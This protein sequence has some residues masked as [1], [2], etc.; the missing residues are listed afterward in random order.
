MNNS[1]ARDLNPQGWSGVEKVTVPRLHRWEKKEE[2]KA[3]HASRSASYLSKRESTNFCRI[4]RFRLVFFAS[5]SSAASRA[6]L[7]VEIAV[8]MLAG[9]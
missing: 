1:N 5:T 7:V 3:T 8:P 4:S 2:T 9:R 6:A